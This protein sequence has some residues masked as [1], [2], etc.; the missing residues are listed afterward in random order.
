MGAE[1]VGSAVEEEVAET[2]VGVVG[3]T[4][5]EVLREAVAQPHVGVVAPA[6]GPRLLSGTGSAHGEHTGN[7]LADDALAVAGLGG[8]EQ[9]AELHL[10]GGLAEHRGGKALTVGCVAPTELVGS[11]VAVATAVAA[12]VEEDI[13]TGGAYTLQD[14]CNIAG[15][16]NRLLRRAG[17]RGHPT[18]R[19]R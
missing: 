3:E 4:G 2:G 5:D 1:S 9:L 12:P 16:R 10:A 19:D 14:A 8:D 7:A 6:V 18:G 13:G 17:C 15:G 11:A